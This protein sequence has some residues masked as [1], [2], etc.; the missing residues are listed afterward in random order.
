MLQHSSSSEVCF[1]TDSTDQ[2]LLENQKQR[3]DVDDDDNDD[4]NDYQLNNFRSK[5][6]QAKDRQ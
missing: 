6:Q 4:Q 5:K 2:A 1:H 3:T